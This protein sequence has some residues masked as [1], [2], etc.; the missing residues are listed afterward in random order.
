[1]R[2]ST[3]TRTAAF[4][5]GVF[6][7]GTAGRP[8]DAGMARR[9]RRTRHLRPVVGCIRNHTAP[10]FALGG[11][12]DMNRSKNWAIRLSPDL[13]LEHFGNEEREFFSIS[14]GIVYRF[15][16]KKKK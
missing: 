4:A 5:S 10:I 11:S 6:D 7:A 8:G 3:S 2:R 14:G 13:I 9:C 1:M 15:P 16:V 12:L